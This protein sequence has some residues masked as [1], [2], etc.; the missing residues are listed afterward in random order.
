MTLLKVFKCKTV[1][2]SISVTRSLS[3]NKYT[4]NAFKFIDGQIGPGTN[5]PESKSVN[6][7]EHVKMSFALPVYK[8][9]NGILYYQMLGS[10]EFDQFQA[11]LVI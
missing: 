2:K 1:H 7:F 11:V 10:I 5:G 3:A 9:I 4:F 8:T 6:K